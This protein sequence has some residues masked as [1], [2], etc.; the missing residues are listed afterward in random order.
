[1]RALAACGV[2]WSGEV[3][4]FFHLRHLGRPRARTLSEHLE[5][6]RWVKSV[7]ARRLDH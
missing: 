5:R 2:S 6:M 3:I 7:G 4:R 1:M